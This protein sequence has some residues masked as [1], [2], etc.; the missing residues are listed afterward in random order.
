[1]STTTEK[2]PNSILKTLLSAQNLVLFGIFWAVASL[3]FFLLFSIQIPG[4]ER[5]FWYTIGTY[6]L[7]GGAFLISSLLCFRNWRSPQIVSGRSVWLGFFLGMASYFVGII[8]FG[9]WELYW[10]LDPDVSLGDVFF[11]LTY[12]SIGISMFLAIFSRRLNLGFWQWVGVFGI[13]AIGALFAFAVSNPELFPFL[14]SNIEV[15]EVAPAPAGEA[16]DLVEAPEIEEEVEEAADAPGW[17]LAIDE[18]AE[19]WA[20]NVNLAY[21]VLDVALLVIATAL[22]LAFWGG[23]YS[24]S[25]QMIAFATVCLFVADIWFKWAENQPD[26]Q[27]GDLLEVFYVFYPV[28]L[29]IG[30]VLENSLSSSS[31][32][33]RR[34]A[35]RR[36]ASS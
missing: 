5:P 10:E 28:L 34:G 36:T 32:R 17:V 25:W 23:R 13:G 19:P 4:V 11:L 24:R 35:R 15:Q 26:Y 27:S 20:D 12:F 18:F 21:I 7:E 8:L 1:M 31:G 33:S 30:A 16:A 14:S 29:W 6:I 22:F 3:L 9:F 2:S